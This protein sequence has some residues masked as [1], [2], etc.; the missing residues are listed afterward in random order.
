MFRLCF[1]DSSGC[2]SDYWGSV[3]NCVFL[4]QPIINGVSC[5]AAS[6]QNFLWFLYLLC[7]FSTL[8]RT[9]GVLLC[10]WFYL[11][12]GCRIFKGPTH[13]EPERARTTRATL[14]MDNDLFQRIVQSIRIAS[15]MMNHGFSFCVRKAQTSCQ[16]LYLLRQLLNLRFVRLDLF[17]KKTDSRYI[18]LP[19]LHPRH[20][21]R[22]NLSLIWIG[23][24]GVR[25]VLCFLN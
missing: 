23:F 22:G 3:S 17:L 6:K 24:P 2:C 11:L 21:A 19:L 4:K 15:L 13:K 18:P 7:A 20:V 10:A 5:Y 8:P 25:G 1:C 9:A 12:P 14:M 16:S